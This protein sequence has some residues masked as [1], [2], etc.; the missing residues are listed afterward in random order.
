[1]I[2]KC[3]LTV[4]VLLTLTACSCKTEYIEVPKPYAVP[5]TCVVDDVNCSVSG[6]D[7]E[8]I[9]NLLECI[10]NLKKSSEVCR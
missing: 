5:I 4:F 6:S 10:I 1:M 8:V 3:L 7:T 2:L 9:I